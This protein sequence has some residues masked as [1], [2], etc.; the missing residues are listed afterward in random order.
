LTPSFGG[1]ALNFASGNQKHSYY[2]VHS[3]FWYIEP[4]RC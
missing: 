4:L 1:E 2:L 3:I